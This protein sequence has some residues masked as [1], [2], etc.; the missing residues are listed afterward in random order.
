MK[1]N[2]SS[3]TVVKAVENVSATLYDGNVIFR[4]YPERYTKNVIRFTLRTKDATKAGSIV[5]KSGQRQPKTSWEVHQK[6]MDEIFKLSP[7]DNIYVD[8]LYGRQFNTNPQANNV[9]V[10]EEEMEVQLQ[11]KTAVEPTT[12][13]RKYIPVS[14]FKHSP[15]VE[16]KRK[17]YTKKSG[18][19]NISKIIEV[20]K[21]A[22]EHPEVLGDR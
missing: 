8:T 3:R 13:P 14:T 15:I 19:P 10:E 7:K 11:Q 18:K 16:T 2:A 22:F 1:T 4:K 20:I 21:Y 5:T 6:V 12:S 17:I 9:E